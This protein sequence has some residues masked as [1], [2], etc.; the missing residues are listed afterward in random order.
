[1]KNFLLGVMATVLCVLLAGLLGANYQATPKTYEYTNN[2]NFRIAEQAGAYGNFKGEKEAFLAYIN[3]QVALG[4]RVIHI[5]YDPEDKSGY[6]AD[7]IWF[8]REKP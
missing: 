5:K 3:K 4:W 8:E 6:T 2:R 1:M 7:E